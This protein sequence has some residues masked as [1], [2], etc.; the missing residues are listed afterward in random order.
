MNEN[1]RHS[2]HSVSSSFPYFWCRCCGPGRLVGSGPVPLLVT[3]DGSAACHAFGDSF[4]DRIGEGFRSSFGGWVDGSFG[5]RI[6]A[7]DGSTKDLTGEESHLFANACALSGCAGA[8]PMPA[9]SVN[10][11]ACGHEIDRTIDRVNRVC[12]EPIG[13]S[14]DTWP[15]ELAG[16]AVGWW[17]V[18]WW[19]VVWWCVVWWSVVWWSVW[20]SVVWFPKD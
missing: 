15:C 6:G 9:D 16:G 5:G 13:S 19:C 17:C 7:H 1:F 14:H 20:W 12:N 10:S 8:H 3:F 11:W 4:G 18:V 2:G